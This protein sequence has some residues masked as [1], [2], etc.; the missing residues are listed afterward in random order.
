MS[1]LRKSFAI[2]NISIPEEGSVQWYPLEGLLV[3]P[4]VQ[5][6]WLKVL[7]NSLKYRLG[8]GFSFSTETYKHDISQFVIILILHHSFL[9]LHHCMYKFFPSSSIFDCSEDSLCFFL[10]YD[11]LVWVNLLKVGDLDEFEAH[12]QDNHIK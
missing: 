1:K 9:E 6:M 12:K 10:H 3:D 4:E 5:K 11:M 8:D 7:K 2:A